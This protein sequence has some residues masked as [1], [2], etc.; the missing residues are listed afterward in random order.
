[1]MVVGTSLDDGEEIVGEVV[2]CRGVN[3]GIPMGAVLLEGEGEH[4]AVK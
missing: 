4:S 1:M 2:V 3:E